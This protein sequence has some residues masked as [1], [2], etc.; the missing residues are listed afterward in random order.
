MSVSNRKAVLVY[1]VAAHAALLAWFWRELGPLP[2]SAD[3]YVTVAWGLTG[4]AMFVAGLRRDRTY[5]IRGGVA[6]LFLVVAKLFLWDLA[7]LDPL[8]RVLLF[9]GFG[10]L[11]LLLSYHLRN[12]WNPREGGDGTAA[13][14]ERLSR[15]A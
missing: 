15:P 1:R 2:G 9:L 10:G 8:W 5:L 3:A 12:L 14:D 13:P 11:F 7:G 4:A 6:T